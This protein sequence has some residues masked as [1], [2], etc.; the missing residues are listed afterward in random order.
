M[1]QS[2]TIVLERNT[3]WVGAFATEPC[4]A[5]WAHEA[6]FFVRCLE[7]NVADQWLHAWVEISPD[8]MHW[9]RE[10]EV[11]SLPNNM[12]RSGETVSFCRVEQFGSWLRLAGELPDGASMRVIA[13]LTLKE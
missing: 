4:E 11:L 1:R 3:L 8:G 12:D 6:I 10:G 5:G 7:T 2:H 9:C 13:Y